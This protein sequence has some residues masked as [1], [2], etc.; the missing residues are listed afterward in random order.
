MQ[1]LSD[2]L[3]ARAEDGG[4]RVFCSFQGQ[5]TTFEQLRNG[6]QEMAGAL[7]EAGV[8]SGDRVGLMLSP[9][10]EHMELFL[11]IAWIGAISVP[12]SIHLKAAGLELQLNSAKPRLLI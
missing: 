1:I 6:V 10:I 5:R 12:F 3:Q 2:L 4:Q 8:K 7:T 9:S 11:A